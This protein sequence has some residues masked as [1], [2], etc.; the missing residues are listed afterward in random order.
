MNDQYRHDL[1]DAEWAVLAPF[2]P[3]PPR[4]RG[5]QW[6]A[7]RPIV[8]GILHRLRTGTPWRDLPDRFGPWQTVYD[9]FRDLRISGRLDHLLEALQFRLNAAGRIDTDLFCID[10]TNV[11]AARAGA[12][13]GGEKPTPR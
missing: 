1:S 9:R 3:T 13:A 2:F 7:H 11:R 6:R 5:G 12:G 8:N 4:R 10:G